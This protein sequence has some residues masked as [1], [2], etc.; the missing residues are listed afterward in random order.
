MKTASRHENAYTLIE[1]LIG[2]FITALATV[3]YLAVR[4][5]HGPWLAAAAAA[6]AVVAGISL[7]VIFY[8][9][10]W[11]RDRRQLT[12]LRE[13]HRTIYRLKEL[14]SDARSIVKPEWAEIQIGDYGWDARPG[15]RDGLIHLQGLTRQWQV[16][17]HAGFRPDQ[18]EKVAEKPSSQYDYWVPYW[19]RRPPPPPCPFPVQERNT[20]TM[21]LPHHSGRYFKNYPAQYYLSSGIESPQPRPVMTAAQFTSWR[22][23][24]QRQYLIWIF[25]LAPM[26]LGLSQLCFY[27]DRAKP[28]LWIQVLAACG[29]FA[30][31]A[32]FIVLPGRMVKLSANKNGFQCPVCGN[33]ITVSAG[34]AGWP[35]R[36]LCARCGTQ[37]IESTESNIVP[38]T[39]KPA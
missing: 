34:L 24:P 13:K 5:K 6:L 4:P 18:I 30:G 36:N 19:S 15:R 29:V 14:P 1:L 17:W 12:E 33:K 38:K 32:L 21:G 35:H 27:M 22:K 26:V 16:V 31:L 11:R 37:V 28:A 20:P 39:E 23:A 2:I 25:V 10:S 8:R 9:W 7:V 3:A